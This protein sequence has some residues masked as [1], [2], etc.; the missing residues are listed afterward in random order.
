MG[1]HAY[2]ALYDAID[3]E[4]EFTDSYHAWDN[5]LVREYP[6]R[7]PNRLFDSQCIPSLEESRSELIH[8]EMLQPTSVSQNT[9]MNGCQPIIATAAVTPSEE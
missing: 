2:D 7:K 3:F 4:F 8:M 6:D 5:S 1:D 9:I